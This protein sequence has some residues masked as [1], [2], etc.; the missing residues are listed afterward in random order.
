MHQIFDIDD[1]CR[2]IYKAACDKVSEYV[3]NKYPHIK[4]F[5]DAYFNWSVDTDDLRFELNK[6]RDLLVKLNACK[7]DFEI[8]KKCTNGRAIRNDWCFNIEFLYLKIVHKF[9]LG[10]SNSMF[11]VYDKDI[12]NVYFY[13]RKMNSHTDVKSMKTIIDW[14]INN[15][16]L[17][18]SLY[19]EEGKNDICFEFSI[20]ISNLHYVSQM[21]LKGLKDMIGGSVYNDYVKINLYE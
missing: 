13:H 20:D 4:E 19:Q 17:F 14:L 16:E 3:D 9:N 7:S 5:Y 12:Q 11:Y 18:L 8:L 1:Y 10:Y 2:D 21:S 15:Q 6:L